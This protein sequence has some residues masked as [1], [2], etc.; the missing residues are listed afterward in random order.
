[1]FIR[2]ITLFQDLISQNKKLLLKKDLLKKLDIAMLLDLD[3]EMRALQSHEI[4][5]HKDALAHFTVRY[6]SFTTPN[7]PLDAPLPAF[8]LAEHGFH[9]DS[10][11][12]AIKCVTCD[13]TNTDLF[14]DLLLSVLNKHLRASPQCEQ[15]R[16]SLSLILSESSVAAEPPLEIKLGGVAIGSS[17]PTKRPAASNTRSSIAAVAAAA[18]NKQ[19]ATEEARI[20]S[21]DNEKLIIGIAKLAANGLYRVPKQDLLLLSASKDKA[22]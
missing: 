13:Y 17:V 7:Y 1:M 22:G 2:V 5:T 20:R 19:F 18:I 10:Y 3:S 16:R 9:F 6:S 14:D 8:A 21:F 15:A 4:R 11:T 12:R